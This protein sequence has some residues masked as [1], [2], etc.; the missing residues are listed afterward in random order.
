MKVYT[1]R[2]GY[3]APSGSAQLVLNTTVKS[4]A[5]LGLTLQPPNWEL[6]MN[7]KKGLIGED[8]YTSAYVDALR[9][10]YK[11]NKQP[12]LDILQHEEVVILCFCTAGKFCHRHLALDVL[13][14]IAL[15]HAIPFER[16]GELAVTR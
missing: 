6:V 13:E 1:S 12:F 3:S 2:I 14:K 4:G 7:Y 11:A 15:A 16:G 5:G 9:L 10:R 8:A